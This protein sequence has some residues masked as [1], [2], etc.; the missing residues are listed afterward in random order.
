MNGSVEP[1]DKSNFTN[2]DLFQYISDLHNSFDRH[3][4][5]TEKQF[6][7]HHNSLLGLEHQ[8]ALLQETVGEIVSGLGLNGTK[9]KTVATMS[10]VQL[11][12]TAGGAMATIMLFVKVVA[13]IWPYLFDI[14][15]AIFQMMIH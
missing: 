3:K 7:S 11:M 4:N 2:K 5:E 12:A 13:A 1:P 10:P 9:K 8:L 14:V 6:R 15:K